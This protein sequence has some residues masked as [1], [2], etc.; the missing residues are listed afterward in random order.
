MDEDKNVDWYFKDYLI[1]SKTLIKILGLCPN[2]MYTSSVCIVHCKHNVN[3]C[4]MSECERRGPAGGG[5]C[6]GDPVL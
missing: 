5:G 1:A 6:P 3:V 2:N 4:P